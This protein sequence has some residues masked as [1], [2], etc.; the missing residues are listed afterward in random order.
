[1]WNEKSALLSALIAITGQSWAFAEGGATERVWDGDILYRRDI[2][3]HLESGGVPYGSRGLS[4]AALQRRAD[5]T[6]LLVYGTHTTCCAGDFPVLEAMEFA[7][8][9]M[10]ARQHKYPF[11]VA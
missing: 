11:P 9:D 10:V 2:W 8:R 7:T 3:E 4:W 5:R 6:G 1:M